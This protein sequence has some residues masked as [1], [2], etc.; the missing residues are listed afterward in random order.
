MFSGVNC[1]FYVITV[2]GRQVGTRNNCFKMLQYAKIKSVMGVLEV[3]W[4]KLSGVTKFRVPL[5][6]GSHL[7]NIAQCDIPIFYLDKLK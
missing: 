7:F 3:H 4:G 6:E 1:E 5:A 2:S